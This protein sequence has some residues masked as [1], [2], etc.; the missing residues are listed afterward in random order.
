MIII[1]NK[2]RFQLR[3]GDKTYP[4]GIGIAA[5]P[6]PTGLFRIYSKDPDPSLAFGVGTRSMLFHRQVY[7]KNRYPAGSYRKLSIHG[8]EKPEEIGTC[9]TLGCVAMY[10][11]DVEELYDRVSLWDKLL[12][13]SKLDMRDW[14]A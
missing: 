6:T 2:D 14:Y 9:C 7:W 4:V 11:Q 3:Y 1:V 12:I 5:C 10:D 13:C 8:I